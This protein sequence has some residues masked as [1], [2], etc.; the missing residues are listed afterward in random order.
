MRPSVRLEPIPG[1]LFGEMFNAYIFDNFIHTGTF[2]ECQKQ[3]RHHGEIVTR[4]SIY[5][6]ERV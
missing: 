3:L 1:G 2:E 5:R 6:G 4:S